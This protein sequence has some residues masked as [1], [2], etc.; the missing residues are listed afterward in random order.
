MSTND[1]KFESKDELEAWL[2]DRGVGEDGVGAAAET[3]FAQGVKRSSQLL[4]IGSGLLERL[5]LP[6]LLSVDL[7]NKL[8]NDQQ[9]VSQSNHSA[10]PF[11]RSLHCLT[12]QLVRHVQAAT[13]TTAKW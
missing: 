1:K 2:K 12:L 8:S 7:S 11:A 13:T 3:L 10:W 9:Q 4:N 6:L 5:G